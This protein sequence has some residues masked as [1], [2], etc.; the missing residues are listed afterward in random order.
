MPRV[1]GV[2][3]SHEE[4]EKLL[5]KCKELNLTT[6]EYIKALILNSLNEKKKK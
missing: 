1:T 2:F 3:L 5:E 4:Y 6:Y